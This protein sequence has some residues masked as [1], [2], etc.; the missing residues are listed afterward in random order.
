MCLFQRPGQFLQGD[1]GLRPD[2]LDQERNLRFEL[3]RSPGRAALTLWRDCAPTAILGRKP[4]SRA[5]T[6]ANTR[7][8]ARSA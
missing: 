6:D 5:D 8:A 3:A 2:D 4:D 1:V 7:A